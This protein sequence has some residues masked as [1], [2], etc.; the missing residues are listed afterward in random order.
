MKKYLLLLVLLLLTGEQ[1]PQPVSNLERM[2]ELLG[3]MLQTLGRDWRQ[4][5]VKS[6]RINLEGDLKYFEGRILQEEKSL[7]TEAGEEY[8][9]TISAVKVHYRDPERDGFFGEMA[10]TREV[11]LKLEWYSE[12]SGLKDFESSLT[13]TITEK[14]IPDA[15]QQYLPFT[16]GTKEPPGFFSGYFEEI[17]AAVVTGV[18]AYLFFSVRSK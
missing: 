5:G 1:M 12:S 13:D 14:N 11:Y 3:G 4:T 18:A 15:E 7:L 10:Y 9:L 17:T 16:V 2:D 6:L 8:I